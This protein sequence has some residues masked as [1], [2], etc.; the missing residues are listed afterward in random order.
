MIPNSFTFLTTQKF[1]TASVYSLI[2][3]SY[4]EQICYGCRGDGVTCCENSGNFGSVSSGVCVNFFDGDVI[5]S[6][7][8]DPV[9][10]GC[11]QYTCTENILFADD[12]NRW[13]MRKTT[14]P[15]DFQHLEFKP[16][17]HFF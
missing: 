17:W 2:C 8:Y 12:A 3:P 1:I 15:G 7:D 5:V 10:S 4:Y 9:T 16:L 6:V 13:L 11:A 14:N